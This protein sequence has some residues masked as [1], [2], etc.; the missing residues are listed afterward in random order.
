MKILL[1]LFL[2]ISLPALA[3]T[4]GD[5]TLVITSTDENLFDA[6][7]NQLIKDGFEIKASD[8]K[9]QT[10]STEW[11]NIE[12]TLNYRLILSVQDNQLTI[13]GRFKNDAVNA[14]FNAPNNENVIEWGK[15]GSKA[16]LWEYIEVFGSH[17][18]TEKKYK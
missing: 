2:F 12:Y 17:F 5:N 11:K 16:K 1:Y 6:A 13:Q 7:M 14:Q 9:Y 4:K 10:I 8:E 3:Q 18:G 15:S